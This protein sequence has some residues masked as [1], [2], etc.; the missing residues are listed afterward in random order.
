MRLLPAL[1]Q[2]SISAADLHTAMMAPFGAAAAIV[3][4]V[5]TVV[6]ATAIASVVMAIATMIVAAEITPVVTVVAAMIATGTIVMLAVTTITLRFG[7]SGGAEAESREGESCGDDVRKLHGT[8]SRTR[9]SGCPAD[10][11]IERH[12]S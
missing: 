8:S 12:G 7:R 3:V 1:Y 6:A 9:R 4:L 5:A 11:A 10:T 2:R